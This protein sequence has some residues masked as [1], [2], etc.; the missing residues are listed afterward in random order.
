MSGSSS[1]RDRVQALVGALGERY[2]PLSW[3]RA[4]PE[5][6][7]IG[8]VLVQQ[9]RWENV[10]RA[11]GRLREAG[12]LT[13]EAI[14]RT[15]AG[16]VEEA[17]R[18]AGFFRVKTRRLKALA[19]FVL[20]AYGSVEAM[21][22]APTDELR[23]GLLGVPGIGEETAD[24]ILC[25]AFDRCS[26]VIDAYTR[27]LCAC[28]GVEEPAGGYRPLFEAVL[29]RENARYRETHAHIVEHGKRYCSR[30]RCEGCSIRSSDA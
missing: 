21:A 16:T 25:Y 23:R 8:A 15:P 13:F 4:P 1:A 2:G 24:A 14:D 7:M 22:R 18:C 19:R 30:R 20:G 9:T 6:V 12:L 5:E 17:V 3:W 11:L 29:P 10:E 27:R 28:A 26:F